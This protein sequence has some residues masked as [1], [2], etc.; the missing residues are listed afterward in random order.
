MRILE[1]W[2]VFVLE[3]QLQI[4]IWNLLKAKQKTY[5]YNLPY[6]VKNELNTLESCDG[7]SH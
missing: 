3:R 7:N 2:F 4:V 5:D 6:S 1:F